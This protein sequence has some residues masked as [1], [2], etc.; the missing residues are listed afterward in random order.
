MVQMIRYAFVSFMSE[1]IGLYVIWLKT[2]SL[3][4][5]SY[6]QSAIYMQSEILQEEINAEILFPS[7]SC[8]VFPL[9]TH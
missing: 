9:L 1:N 4:S 5:L 7:I 8:P 6:S 2:T 3:F